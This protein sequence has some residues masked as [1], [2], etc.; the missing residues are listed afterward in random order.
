MMTVLEVLVI[1]GVFILPAILTPRKRNKLSIGTNDL[2]VE[3][4]V[5]QDGYL[6]RL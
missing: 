4:G 3:Y 2:S 6:V 5:D 1:V